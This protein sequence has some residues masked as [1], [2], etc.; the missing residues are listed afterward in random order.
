MCLCLFLQLSLAN[1]I[2]ASAVFVYLPVSESSYLES[3]ILMVSEILWAALCLEARS[4]PNQ[5]H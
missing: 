5:L 4:S 3:F 2:I 1:C